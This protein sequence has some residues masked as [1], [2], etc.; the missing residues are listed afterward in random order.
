M[1]QDILSFTQQISG[2]DL[3]YYVIDCID[4]N[5]IVY[6]ILKDMKFDIKSCVDGASIIYDIRN[7]SDSD[8]DKLRSLPDQQVIEIYGK[9]YTVCIDIFEDYN[10]LYISVKS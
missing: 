7:L 8:M 5:M 4:Q 2:I 3:V 6:S 9:Q 1:S 10:R